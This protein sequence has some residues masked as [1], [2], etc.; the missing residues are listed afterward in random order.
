[1]SSN[2]EALGTKSERYRDTGKVN[3]VGMEKNVTVKILVMGFAKQPVKFQ[4][5]FDKK[6]T[7]P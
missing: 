4:N 2:N 3:H 5:Y 6:Q 7:Q 1:M